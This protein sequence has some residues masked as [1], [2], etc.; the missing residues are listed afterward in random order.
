MGALGVVLS[1]PSFYATLGFLQG[2]EPL[3]VEAFLAQPPVEGLDGGIVRW[4]AWP[5]EG[6]LHAMVVRLGIEHLGSELGT[7]VHLDYLGKTPL[8]CDPLQDRHHPL[9]GQRPTSMAGL[10][11]V[12]VSPS[13]KSRKRCPLARRSLRK[14]IRHCSLGACAA[15]KGGRSALTRCLRTGERTDSPSRR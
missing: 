9:A 8:R 14:S 12:M 11:R 10:S 2:E 6:Q 15:G 1:P 4:G 13:V 3:L 7:I 5:A